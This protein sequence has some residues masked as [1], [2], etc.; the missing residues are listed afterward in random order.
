[1]RL[2]SPI[3]D[4]ITGLILFALGI[5]MLVGGFTMDR[6]EIRQIHPASIPGL[7]PMGL[8]LAM[9]LCAFLL[10]LSTLQS[11]SV[12][13]DS[14]REGVSTNLPNEKSKSEEPGSYTNLLVTVF[15]TV[16]YGAGLVGHV[17]FV[18]ATAIFIFLFSLYFLWTGSGTKRKQKS[19]TITLC[20]VYA[21]VF[22]VGISALFRYGF[23]VRLP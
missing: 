9:A 22:A 10:I 20:A 16:G 5:S 7:L 13:Y 11:E 12:R 2:E 18:V 21:V 8:G 6:L 15:L 19:R 1:M 17:P 4:R 3:A 14:T 23:L